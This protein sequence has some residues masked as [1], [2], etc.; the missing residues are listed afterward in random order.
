MDMDI[1]TDRRDVP[2]ATTA[3]AELDD[4]QSETSESGADEQIVAEIAALVVESQMQ[5]RKHR[6]LVQTSDQSDLLFEP[7]DEDAN[8]PGSVSVVLEEDVEKHKR[9]ELPSRQATDDKDE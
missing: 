5:L 3:G 6:E 2:P 7:E 1:D 9:S 8:E 4:A